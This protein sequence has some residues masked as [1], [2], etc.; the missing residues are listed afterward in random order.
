M[1][2]L[3]KIS[4]DPTTL[5]AIVTASSFALALSRQLGYFAY[6]EPTLIYSLSVED[7]L[8]NS[9]TT[10]PITVLIWSILWNVEPPRTPFKRLIGILGPSTSFFQVACNVS[11][12]SFLIYCLTAKWLILVSFLLIFVGIHVVLKLSEDHQVSF[13]ISLGVYFLITYF[14]FGMNEAG[15]ALSNPEP[16]AKVYTN[17]SGKI[18][19]KLL[20]WNSTN[21]IVMNRNLTI[22]VIA[23]QE[24]KAVDFDTPV[25]S[26]RFSSGWLWRFFESIWSFVRSS[27]SV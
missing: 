4:D 6:L 7:Y 15:L 8:R 13:P 19:A 23:A 10:V 3:K 26:N 22:Q 20:R 18:E 2:S 11:L 17:S 1:T 5:I 21:V 24:I 9:I 14:F 12:W 27:I 25:G 16:T